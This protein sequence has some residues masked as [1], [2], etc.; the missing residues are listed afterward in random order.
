LP[1]NL[2]PLVGG[3][4]FLAADCLTRVAL[5]VVDLFCF[6]FRV[7][8]AMLLRVF[9]VLTPLQRVRIPPLFIERRASVSRNLTEDDEEAAFRQHGCSGQQLKSWLQRVLGH[10]ST[11]DAYTRILRKTQDSVSTPF[12]PMD[13]GAAVL[14]IQGH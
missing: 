2:R 4:F 12:I 3:Y 13:A 6:D 7:V 11:W 10:K 5:L 8:L 9:C 14:P 1:L